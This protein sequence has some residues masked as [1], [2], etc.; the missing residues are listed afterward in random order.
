MQLDDTQRH[1]DT[2][3]TNL[4]LHST[5]NAHF[6]LEICIVFQN[7]G[8]VKS[9]MFKRMHKQVE[10]VT[11]LEKEKEV[12]NERNRMRKQKTRTKNI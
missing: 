11:C 9:D 3:P 4:Q 5:Q 2:Q 1:N 8:T 12:D 10:E 7:S 6:D